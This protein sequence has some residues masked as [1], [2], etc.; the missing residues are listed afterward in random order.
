M[1]RM[2]AVLLL[3]VAVESPCHATEAEEPNRALY[4]RYCGACHGPEGRGDGVAGTFYRTKPTDLTQ[5]AKKNHGEFPFKRTMEIID[6]RA[7]V[8]AHGDPEMPV[9]G[10]V[11]SDQA[12]SDMTRRA[13]ARGKVML[14]TDYIRS[15]QQK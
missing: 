10:D 2:T 3:A 15:I 4:L 8:R 11:F 1:G 5:I 12:G 13:D 14:I 7:T 9:W 6:G